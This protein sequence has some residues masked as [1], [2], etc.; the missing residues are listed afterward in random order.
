M[1]AAV[2]LEYPLSEAASGPT[3]ST[4]LTLLRSEGWERLAATLAWPPLLVC[5]RVPVGVSLSSEL[6]SSQYAASGLVP[7]MA[8]R[9]VVVVV[10]VLW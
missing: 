1:V 2:W 9:A 6:A 10:V 5:R 4:G 8:L 3:T 7:A